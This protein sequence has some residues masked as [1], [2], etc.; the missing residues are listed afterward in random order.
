MLITPSPTNNYEDPYRNP[1]RLPSQ[2]RPQQFVYLKYEIMP[3]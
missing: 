2:V 3:L 1:G